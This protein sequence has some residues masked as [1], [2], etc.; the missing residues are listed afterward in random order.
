MTNAL[1]RTSPHFLA[2]MAAIAGAAHLL[3]APPI[4][5]PLRMIVVLAVLLLG[6]GATFVFDRASARPY[7]QLVLAVILVE[8]PVVALQ[9]SAVR[10]PFVALGRG[11][12]GFAISMTI[13]CL[14]VLLGLLVF[15]VLVQRDPAENTALLLLLPALVVPAVL[16]A[17]SELDETASLAMFGESAL[18]AGVAAFVA[19]LGPA[20]WRPLLAAAAFVLQFVGLLVVGKGPVIGPEPG[21]VSY[22]CVSLVLMAALG[23]IILA[24]VGAMFARRFFQTVDERAGI[25]APA[26]VPQRGARRRS[27]S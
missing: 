12:S 7:W 23:L 1:W 8:M 21:F 2:G 14:L 27:D 16:G 5:A 10:T 3:P 11:S 18:L 13:A 20:G 22:F 26:R 9:S 19:L 6:I 15:G 25:A 17:G 24:P 4:S